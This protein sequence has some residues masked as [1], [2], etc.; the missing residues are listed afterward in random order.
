M[1]GGGFIVK[2]PI[3]L[4]LYIALDHH[5]RLSPSTHS[6]PH[7]KQLQLLSLFYFI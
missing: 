3:R 7:L 5:H 6:L 4:I 2:I 1:V